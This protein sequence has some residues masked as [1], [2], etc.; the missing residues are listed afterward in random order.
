MSKP[1]IFFKISRRIAWPLF[2]FILNIKVEGRKNIPSKGRYI[3]ISNH[4]NWSDPFYIYIIFPP[5]PKII[6][7]AEN[8]GIYDTPIKRK[9][10]DLMGRPIIPINRDKVISRGRGFKKMYE[11]VESGDILAVFP[12]G[13]LG[14]EEGKLF[15][16][17]VGVF[18]LAKKLNVPILPVTISGS[19]KLSFRNPVHIRIGKLTYCQQEESGRDYARR[20]ALNMK[21]QLPDFPG[22]GPFPNCA[23]WLTGL[24]QGEIREFN[25]KNTL[26]IEKDDKNS[27]K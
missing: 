6:F 24:A 4:L 1:N 8:E 17:H 14:H 5:A 19:K 9:F 26:I 25:G 12:E 10:I 21:E 23:K 20:M 13:R 16:F 18:R 27:R 2:D 7:V 11:V 15:P 3:I 22:E